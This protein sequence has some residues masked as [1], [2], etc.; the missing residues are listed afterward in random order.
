M[1]NNEQKNFSYETGKMGKEPEE[2]KVITKITLENG[3]DYFLYSDGKIYEKNE[4]GTLV[5]L[6]NLNLESQK[7]ID[8][9]M[10]KLRSVEFDVVR[11][12]NNDKERRL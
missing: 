10:N 3:K 6:D 9:I 5:Q 1:E 2:K 8:K 4:K 11:R 7:T 12:P